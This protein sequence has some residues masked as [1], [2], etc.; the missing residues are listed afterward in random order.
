M[1]AI[2]V[3]KTRRAVRA[4]KAEP[5]PRRIIEDIVDCGRLAATAINIQPWEFV[6]VTDPKTLRRVAETTDYGKFI[7]GV[8]VCVL[9]LCQDT[10]YYLED[11]SA[12]TENILLAARAHGLGSCWVAGDKKP[13][14][15][16]ICRLMGAP[17]GYKLVSLIPDGLSGG[18]PGT[19]QAAPVRRSAL[20][21]VLSTLFGNPV[22]AQGG[23]KG[24]PLCRSPSGP[25]NFSGSV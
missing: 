17:Q 18:G 11:G 13:Y 6:V 16:E 1:D 9:V 20:G 2:E 21:E 8:P 23:H 7:A 22:V 10:K 19:N 5:V 14:A 3:F 15:A 24:R 12:A 4:Y 25:R